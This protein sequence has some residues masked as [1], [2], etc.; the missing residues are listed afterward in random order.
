MPIDLVMDKKENIGK[1][2]GDSDS[3]DIDS[4]P[5]SALPQVL[6]PDVF[7]TERHARALSCY[8]GKFLVLWTTF[9]KV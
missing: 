7:T 5:E 2:R 3:L 6:K 9:L 4:P 1:S 8:F